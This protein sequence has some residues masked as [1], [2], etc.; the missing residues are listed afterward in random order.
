MT[1]L[2][3]DTAPDLLPDLDDSSQNSPET[4]SYLASLGKASNEIFNAIEVPTSFEDFE[5]QLTSELGERQLR[6]LMTGAE[7]QRTGS[8]LDDM[9]REAAVQGATPEDV[10]AILSGAF[11]PEDFVQETIASSS[12]LERGAAEWLVQQGFKSPERAAQIISEEFRTDVDVAE[13]DV[14]ED[15]LSTMFRLNTL[16]LKLQ[17]KWKEQGFTES[18]FDFLAMLVPGHETATSAKVFGRGAERLSTSILNF[19]EQFW[20]APVTKRMAIIEQFEKDLTENQGFSENV[21]L[22]M[23]Q[24]NDLIEFKQEDALARD[25]I[26]GLDAITVAFP[27]FAMFRAARTVSG[28]ARV[29]GAKDIPVAR[30][31]NLREVDRQVQA[32][33]EADP[34]IGKVTYRNIDEDELIESS[35]PSAISTETEIEKAAGPAVEALENTDL[36]KSFEQVTGTVLAQAERQGVKL[37]RDMDAVDLLAL[38]RGSVAPEVLNKS[39]QSAANTAAVRA[40]LKEFGIEGEAKAIIDPEGSTGGRVTSSH[41]PMYDVR[42]DEISGARTVHV[43]LGT[44]D[45]RLKGFTSEEAALKGAERMGLEKGFFKLS[46]RS[47]EWYVRVSR[48]PGTAQFIEG[49][50]VEEFPFAVPVLSKWILGKKVTSTVDDLKGARLSSALAS[51]V[52]EGISGTVN[53][54]NRLT[55]DSKQSYRNLMMDIQE[56]EKWK[57]G[58]QVKDWYSQ[59][60]NRLPNEKELD[61]YRATRQLYDF[62]YI[63]RNVALKDEL[64][65]AGY[66]EVKVKGVHAS[67]VA[68]KQVNSTSVE[69]SMARIYDTR[70]ESLIDIPDRASLAKVLEDE[71]LVLIKTLE[72]T[73]DFGQYIITPKTGF[74]IRPLRANVLNRVNGPH[75]IYDGDN[76]IKQQRVRFIK[77]RETIV[78]PKTHFAI[79]S[80][81]EAT[82]YVDDYNE[83][84][85]AYLKAKRSNSAAERTLA[86]ETISRNTRFASFDEFDEAVSSGRIETTPFELVGNGQLP[87]YRSDQ[88][89]GSKA[90]DPDF[91]NL[92]DDIQSLVNNGRMFYSRRG[93]RLP[94]PK[95]GLATLLKPEEILKRSISNVVN[96]QAY[97]KYKIRQVTRWDKTFGKYMINFDP[98]RP[99]IERFMFGQWDTRPN[100]PFK[101]PP[102]AQRAAEAQRLNIKRFLN[103]TGLVDEG[104]SRFRQEVIDVIDAKVNKKWADRFANITSNDFIAHARG[105]SFKAYLGNL[106]ISQLIV[107][108]AMWPGIVTAFPVNGAKVMTALPHIRAA[109]LNPKH[110]KSWA[111]THESFTLKQGIPANRFVELVEDLQKSGFD[112]VDGNLGDLDN[113]N[114]TANLMGNTRRI[115]KRVTDAGTIFFREAEKANRIAAF[116][117]AWLEHVGKIGKRPTT[118]DEFGSIGVRADAFAGNMN[119]DGKAAWQNGLPSLGTQFWGHPARVMENILAP[120]K[121]GFTPTDKLRF[122]SG[123][124]LWYGPLLS[125][126][127]VLSAYVAQQMRDAGVE[128]NQDAVNIATRGLMGYL[129]PETETQRLAPIGNIP[130]AQLFDSEGNVDAV[131]AILGAG[132][133]LGSKFVEATIGSRKL[134]A[135]MKNEFEPDVEPLT[136]HDMGAGLLDISED[137]ARVLSSYSRAEKAIHIWQTKQLLSKQGQVLQ[138]DLDKFDA[139]MQGLGFPPIESSRAFEASADHTEM[140][141]K[142]I[143][144]ARLAFSFLEKAVK[145][146]KGTA[147]Y[148]LNWKY[149][150]HMVRMNHVNTGDGDTGH[151]FAQE[152]DKLAHR[153]GKVYTQQVFER[154]YRDLGKAPVGLVR[155]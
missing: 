38:I 3:T 124:A 103:T 11:T 75:R 102:Q 61:A 16:K 137:A 21:L 24:L 5:G 104:I 27:I 132:G 17:D 37:D 57:T 146:D 136:L 120:T 8:I 119:R 26:E 20:S 2:F 60:F 82:K 35:V 111:K 71:N 90:I 22:A 29:A 139:V 150:M 25:A 31:V 134:W 126:G 55:G 49:A 123:L 87:N 43:Y 107:Q 99:A 125:G 10:N 80:K 63:V 65:G 73:K 140:K 115:V 84:L 69:P 142:L 50:K 135:L 41:I 53:R 70:T 98:G 4:A 39:E 14:R 74:N 72:D 33:R 6:A 154:I 149:F 105:F 95:E 96:T 100:A 78:T 109:L 112:I 42:V 122:Y 147:E 76:F 141:K 36:Q 144:D 28:A 106:D 46:N 92:S 86:S 68:G 18:T 30:A 152:L 79:A 101:L 148:K 83:A 113:L 138:E 23:G 81:S 133:D 114:N 130:L 77:G 45:N 52:Q 34:S 15:F 155:E 62:D 145:A 117:M 56:Q 131:G 9:A 7:R 67:P 58:E 64:V 66:Q 110:V 151:L 54:I 97:N 127:S 129:L 48:N 143:K 40:I 13:T 1:D 19:S 51:K 108:M 89:A 153:S 12:V 85:S 118:A 47:G 121:G 44:G 128:V 94:H 59:N 93:E 32:A 88:L 91:A 116:S